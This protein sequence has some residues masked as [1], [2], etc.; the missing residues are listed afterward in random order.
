MKYI[1]L[2]KTHPLEDGGMPEQLE[3]I[4]NDCYE[5]IHNYFRKYISRK[6]K[7][8]KDVEMKILFLKHLPVDLV[9]YYWNVHKMK[10]LK[11][12]SGGTAWKGI[13]K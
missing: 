1:K 4:F 5:I 7:V 8:N 10:K 12:W 6:G 9:K 3:I 13:S 11:S 2:T